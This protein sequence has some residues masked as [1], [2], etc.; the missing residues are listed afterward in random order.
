MEC[1]NC[2]SSAK[3]LSERN[4]FKNISCSC[5]LFEGEI[6]DRELVARLKKEAEAREAARINAEAAAVADENIMSKVR[7]AVDKAG[8]DA[9]EKVYEQNINAILE[10]VC[11]VEESAGSGFL[12]STQ[13]YAITNTH[14]VV[15]RN[16]N[17]CR[18]IKALCVG[19]WV[20]VKVLALFGASGTLDDIALIKLDRVPAGASTV[21]LGNSDAVKT[22]QQSFVIGNSRGMGTCIMSGIISDKNREGFILTNDMAKHGNSGG[23]LFTKDGKVF[24]VLDK[25]VGADLAQGVTADK[26][27]GVLVAVEVEGMNLSIPI[28]HVKQL[29]AKAERKFGIRVL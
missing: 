28:N 4:G 14:V 7:A 21:K 20:A 18:E 12:V 5:C 8:T 2:G 25:G 13:G 15:D 9:G 26:N 11:T 22:G 24:S 19:Q 27:E 6:E 3:V 23:P 1:P 29:I 16:N 10:I 17:V